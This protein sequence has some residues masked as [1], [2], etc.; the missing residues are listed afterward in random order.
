MLHAIAYFDAK[1]GKKLSTLM[2]TWIYAAVVDYMNL[3]YSGKATKKKGLHNS[4]VHMKF[5]SP[6]HE[7][8]YLANRPIFDTNVVQESNL[9]EGFKIENELKTDDEITIPVSLDAL[10]K[11]EKYVIN[12]LYNPHFELN[13]SNYFDTEHIHLLREKGEY[14]VLAKIM[15][16]SI[17]EVKRL[18]SSAL[19]KIKEE[20]MIYS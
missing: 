15:N 3:L 8:Q 2:Y 14:T 10:D 7:Q 17:V 13:T 20:E 9:H 16:T 5:E 4:I 18:E 1:Q 6:Q 11:R 19:E 12:V